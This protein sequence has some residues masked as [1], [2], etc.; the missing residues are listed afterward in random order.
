MGAMCRYS[1]VCQWRVCPGIG[2][3]GVEL[4]AVDIKEDFAT[5]MARMKAAKAEVMKRQMDFLNE[6]YD[7]SNRPA[8][9][10]TMSRG[11]AVQEGVRVNCPPGM[12]WA[13]AGRHEPG[14]IRDKDLFPEGVL[15]AAAS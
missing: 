13:A 5:I 7:L 6:R 9:D 12:T 4:C 11:K 2:P 3:E 8:A 14:R 1:P 10:G 15:S